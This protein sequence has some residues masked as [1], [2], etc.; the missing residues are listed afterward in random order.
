MTSPLRG[1][2]GYAFYDLA[3]FFRLEIGGDGTDL[4][5]RARGSRFVSFIVRLNRSNPL[6]LEQQKYRQ[7]TSPWGY[8][9]HPRRPD[10][11]APYLRII[12]P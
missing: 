6:Q 3:T 4:C 7:S 2:I 5:T 12:P 1:E 10:G 11:L 9:E 8:A